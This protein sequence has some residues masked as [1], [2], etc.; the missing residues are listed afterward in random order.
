MA[1]TL[2]KSADPINAQPGEI[3]LYTVEVINDDPGTPYPPNDVFFVDQGGAGA[4]FV[5]GSVTIEN[6]PYP[7][8]NPTIGF[9]IPIQIITSIS[10]TYQCLI[11]EQP[12]PVQI[13][14]TAQAIS[15]DDS[16]TYSSD[17]VIVNVEVVNMF[18]AA[19][20]TNAILGGELVYTIIISNTGAV[21][22][23]N[24]VF[25]DLVPP[26]TA[27]VPD[28]FILNGI[29]QLGEDPNNGVSLP[30]ILPGDLVTISFTVTVT[31]VPCPPKL[32]NVATLDFEIERTP[33]GRRDLKSITS[34]EVMTP[35]A[36]STFKQLYK[37]EVVKIPIQKPDI[38]Q[39][40]TTLV[41][42]EITNTKVIKTM[43]GI[44][45]EGQKLTGYKLIVEGIL[46]QKIEYI[47]D[48]PQQ[49]VH[50]AHFRVPFSTFIVLPENF[51]PAI[52][53]VQVEGTVEDIFTEIIDKRTIFKNIT[54]VING[55]ITQ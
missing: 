42:V 38:E 28:S 20:T 55:T 49:S 53:N 32:N 8:L 6:V 25:T 34:N 23:E 1:L 30:D 51:N 2:I 18:K 10:I 52:T 22:L 11:D 19:S 29:P 27:F 41:D 21:P 47:A 43:V 4:S 39:L 37:E 3:I 44:S 46:N 9:N 24:P 35:V 15:S 12:A 50:A 16:T 17:E 31:C 5:P 36:N 14:N 7:G 26:C 45:L 54:F 33:E 48:E 40:L 13:P